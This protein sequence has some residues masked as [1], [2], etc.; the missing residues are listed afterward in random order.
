[1]KRFS[2]KILKKILSIKDDTDGFAV[3]LTLSIF[4]FL[5]VLCAAVY[6]VGETIHQKIRL[7]NACDAAAYSAAVVQAD[8]LSRMATINR[9][10][11]WTYVQM[12]N[13]QMDYITYRWL[14]LTAK[15]FEEDKANA[16]AWHRHLVASWSKE[17]GWWAIIVAAGDALT[18]RLVGAK[19]NRNHRSAGIGWWCGLGS[20]ERVDKVKL[21][22]ANEESIS[23]LESVVAK[24]GERFDVAVPYVDTSEDD[25]AREGEEDDS[26]HEEEEGDGDD[27]EEDDDD[28]EQDFL[29]DMYGTG[30]NNDDDDDDDDELKNNP[31]L[32]KEI[33]EISG[34]KKTDIAALREKMLAEIEAEKQRITDEYQQRIDGLDKE[35]PDYDNR[36]KVLEDERDG[37]IEKSKK[38]IEK[39]YK[40][41]W[42]DINKRYDGEAD[43]AMGKYQMSGG[44]QTQQQGGNA[45]SAQDTRSA[46]DIIDQYKEYIEHNKA[47]NQSS[48]KLSDDELR[49]AAEEAAWEEIKQEGSITYN[50][51]TIQWSF[52]APKYK[53]ETVTININ[54]L[55]IQQKGDSR[56]WQYLKN[57]SSN[58]DYKNTVHNYVH[59]K[60][61]DHYKRLKAEQAERL[62][63]QRQIQFPPQVSTPEPP[64]VDWGAGLA[65]LIDAD[66]ENIALMNAMLS[67]VN[68]NM[69]TAMRSTAEF[70]LISMLKDPRKKKSD[71]LKN[72]MAYFSI[73]MGQDPYST[74]DAEDK[75][76]RPLF[77]PL[78]NT[79]PCERLFLH[80]NSSDHADE[81]LYKLFPYGEGSSNKF[82][83]KGYGLDQWFVRAT[84]NPEGNTPTTIRSEGALGIQ[85]A[86]KDS[87]LNETKAG[88]ILFDAQ[89]DRGNHIAQISTFI[90]NFAADKE[91]D[92]SGE[93]AGGTRKLGKG[94]M[95]NILN[96]IINVLM[97]AVNRFCDINPSAGNKPT[98]DQHLGMC[99]K[100][101]QNV[102]L[103][104]E[105]DWA[106]GKWLCINKPK[107]YSFWADYLYCKY[108]IGKCK[109]KMIFCDY[110]SQKH[111]KRFRGKMTHRGYGHY[112]LPKWFCGYKPRYEG[113]GPVSPSVAKYTL[114]DM[115]P[116]LIATTTIVGRNHGYMEKT[117]DM[118]EF[119]RPFSPLWEGDT[120]TTRRDYRSCA[121]FM[122]GIFKWNYVTGGDAAVIQGHARIY[123]DDQEIWDEARYI[124]ET[125]KPWVLHENFFNGLGTIV[126]GA[127]MKH[128][129]PFV[130]LFNLWG[131]EEK[132]LS[133]KSVLS[134]FDPPSYVG[135]RVTNYIWTMSAARAAVRRT[136][137]D[138][139]NGKRLYQVVY[140]PSSDPHN[141]SIRAAFRYDSVE[142]WKKYESNNGNTIHQ[143]DTVDILGGCVCESSEQDYKGDNTQK[144]KYMWNLCEQDWDATLL[145]LR[146]AGASAT[147]QDGNQLF[148]EKT[149]KERLD[150]IHQLTFKEIGKGTNWTWSPAPVN[151]TDM[152]NANPLNPDSVRRSWQPLDP[153]NED[154]LNLENILPGE[155]S[156]MLDLNKILKQNR[157]L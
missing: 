41:K 25:A 155:G 146:Y 51:R 121:A 45:A 65:Q 101:S 20:R 17:L 95:E 103:I 132:E 128:E 97:G 133:R 108:I 75:V 136:R 28:G 52:Y 94:F 89:V 120:E 27:N 85:R 9:A 60:I 56:A 92:D 88:L 1:M 68:R 7:Q 139:D 71:S 80:M 5:F 98:E 134:A 59:G 70:V 39:E 125:A 79:E 69:N 131:S 104:S 127:A 119:A 147:M 137:R 144:F 143:A 2:M 14:K 6:A 46:Q 107:Y 130:Q 105:Y 118:E 66:K 12:T 72:Y 73:P 44:S 157:I 90:S 18:G 102:A 22:G 140:D 124:G 36:K 141:L 148:S 99:L 117:T 82:G 67:V 153:E 49:K 112:H 43:E 24:F 4:L 77:A 135:G 113:D 55:I 31:E 38:D 33:E 149:H 123:G 91:E 58:S 11:S 61:E 151:G 138:G 63:E 83:I 47:A 40:K 26:P 62:R 110:G 106:S 54:K 3:M 96:P 64:M 29:D 15:R 21:N 8:G 10:M 34:R 93:G 35:D 78:Y 150:F 16:Q 115:L 53:Y 87:N 142:K 19:C 152:G 42:D 126:V 30:D 156:R 114:V 74:E 84:R 13:H 32:K 129:N 100:D 109:H 154:I 81:P 145:P 37:K 50:K 48:K 76:A 23:E 86:Y 116:P 57:F 111:K 122:D